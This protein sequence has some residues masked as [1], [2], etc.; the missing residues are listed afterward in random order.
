MG[1][2]SSP[3]Q[4]SM[5]H[6][7]RIEL[8]AHSLPSAPRS[9]SQVASTHPTVLSPASVTFSP[10]SLMV[11]SMSAK[12]MVSTFLMTGTT[13]PYEGAKSSVRLKCS[14][15]HALEQ[16]GTW[17]QAKIVTTGQERW[18]HEEPST[19]FTLPPLPQSRQNPELQC[20]ATSCLP[21]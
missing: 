15:K 2:A 5:L 8:D 4:K 16:K 18:E 6:L 3:C 7:P 12:F 1:T 10:S 13:R 17:S 19:P 20:Q 9:E 11:R 14:S 21:N